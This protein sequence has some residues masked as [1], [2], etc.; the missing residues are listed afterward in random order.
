M[1]GGSSFTTMSNRILV[2]VL[3]KAMVVIVVSAYLGYKMVAIKNKV[4]PGGSSIGQN[5]MTTFRDSRTKD[6]AVQKTKIRRI[7]EQPNMFYNVKMSECPAAP[8]E[9]ER[10]KRVVNNDHGHEAQNQ[11]TSNAVGIPSNGILQMT[12]TALNMNYIFILN[13]LIATPACIASIVF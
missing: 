3:V 9:V 5:Q 4:T 8:E 7:D 12:K 2:V 11:N 13:C 6:N 1:R 10:N